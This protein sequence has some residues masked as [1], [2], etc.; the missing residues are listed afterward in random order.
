MRRYIARVQ[1]PDGIINYSTG[2]IGEQIFLRWFRDNYQNEQIFQQKADRDYQGIDFAD[3]KGYTYQVKTTK[4]N[5]YTF[6]KSIEDVRDTL[7]AELYVFIQ[8]KD[9]YAYIER[10][11]PSENIKE[12]FNKSKNYKNSCFIWARDLQQQ[13]LITK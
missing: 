1:I 5:S 9:K 2:Y 12:E 11:E 10:I 7:K 3:E 4:S 8:L 13:L 6:N